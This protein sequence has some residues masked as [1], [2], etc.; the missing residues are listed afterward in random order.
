MLFVL[1]M[2]L[3]LNGCAKVIKTETTVVDV[4]VIEIDYDPLMLVGG[5][6]IPADYAILLRY[7]NFDDWVDISRDEYIKYKNLV[8]TFI[9][10]K[11]IVV[12]YDDGTIEQHIELI[13]E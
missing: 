10:A 13:E 7:E 4:L 8:D 3:T 11:L 9:E 2:A 12:Y 1:I 5:I 6:I